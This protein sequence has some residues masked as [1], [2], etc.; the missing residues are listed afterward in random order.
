MAGVLHESDDEQPASQASANAANTFIVRAYFHQARALLERGQFAD[1]E[2]YFREVLRI[3][4]DHASSLNNLGNALWLQDRLDEAEACYRRARALRPNE[5]A[6]LNNL[7]N[8]AREKG[9]L[10]RAVRWYRRAIK[11]KPDSADGLMNFGIALSD[12]GELDEALVHLRESLRLKPD[13]PDC[14]ANLG[15]TFARQGHWDLAL[16][17]YERALA[18]RPCFPEARRNRAY[19]SLARG[20][21]E[22][23]WPE[24]EWRLQCKK[25]RLLPMKCPRWGGENL[26]EQSILLH[27]EQ[28][29]GDSLQFIRY[30]PLVK[31]RVG[32]VLVACPEPLIRLLESCSGVDLVVDW[33][34]PLPDSDVHA[35]IMSLPAILGTT[36]A[37]I[38]AEVPYL[39]PDGTTIEKWRTVV[40]RSLELAASGEHGTP[41]RPFKI[42]IA[43]QGNPV[44]SVDRRRSFPLKHFAHL[45][46]LPG[47][48]LI[49]LQK[50]HGTEQLTELAGRFPVA[51]LCGGERGE[52]DDRDFLDTAAVMSRLDL[53]VA[54]ETAVAH[55]AGALGVRVWVALAAVADWRWMIDRDDSPWYP[56]MRLFRQTEPDDWDGVF[57]R[58]AG[59]LRQEIMA[60]EA[61]PAGARDAA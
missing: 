56:T 45:A 10:E 24:Y 35:P 59:A 51:K 32:R 26:P 31:H 37:S 7:G 27:S 17:S 20:D 43:W 30:A 16:L 55:L 39:F 2:V 9:R 44:N 13:S 40:A 41:T 28:G 22:R 21:Y 38:P 48:R 8:V 47:V 42:G 46:E 25:L 54:P 50:G 34:S 23:G 33:K 49:S 1:A 18:L 19:I 60:P 57:R 11:L 3:W 6:I 15:I 58:M 53:V 12:L 29:L 52:K 5:F 36:L 4:P 14:H 61:V